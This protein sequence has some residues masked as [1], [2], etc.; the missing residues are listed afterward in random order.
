MFASFA[1]LYYNLSICFFV[2]GECEKMRTLYVTDLDGTLLDAQAALSA[3]SAEIINRLIEHGVYFTAATARGWSSTRH[4]L[5][6]LNLQLPVICSN[7]VVLI[8]PLDG[9][10]L[11]RHSIEQSD[12]HELLQKAQSAGFSPLV[13]HL[14]DNRQRVS[15][16]SS[17]E[18]DSLDSRR[19]LLNYVRTRQGDPRLLPVESGQQLFVKDIN[20][21]TFIEMVHEPLEQ[22]AFYSFAKSI[23]CPRLHT[24]LQEDIYTPHEFWLDIFSANATKQRGVLDVRTRCCADE[25]VCF[26]DNI[27]DLPM[28]SVADYCCAVGNAAQKTLEQANEIIGCSCDDAVPIWIARREGIYIDDLL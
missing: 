26:G 8:N 6:A 7:G 25:V 21:I 24:N 4:I 11:V 23:D 22:S 19:G 9:S 14:L 3:R 13:Y 28:F 15:W 1:V 17:P 16:V 5:S 27:N 2:K 10:E 12:A 18:L 20:Y